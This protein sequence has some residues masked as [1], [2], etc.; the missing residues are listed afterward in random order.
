MRA[1]KFFLAF[2]LFRSIARNPSGPATEFNLSCHRLPLLSIASPMYL[3]LKV[4]LFSV[5]SFCG[6]I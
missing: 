4:T 6:W 1:A 2:F 3:A 5:D